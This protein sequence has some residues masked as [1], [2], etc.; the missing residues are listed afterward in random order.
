MRDELDK[1]NTMNKN[2]NDDILPL[3]QDSEEKEDKSGLLSLNEEFDNNNNSEMEDT[4]ED[5]LA[6][7]DMIS[8][9]DEA[10][11]K[12]DSVV[13][14]PVEEKEENIPEQTAQTE[15]PSLSDDIFSIDDMTSEITNNPEE[16]ASKE[17][18]PANDMG[19]IFS[20]VLSAVDGLE[21]K[22]E[23]DLDLSSSSGSNNVNPDSEDL[24]ENKKQKKKSFIKRLFGQK[25][26]DQGDTKQ[27]EKSASEEETAK[28]QEPAEI[29]TK[30][31]KK[32]A[33]PKKKAK[34]AKINKADSG[35]SDESGELTDKKNEKVN[36]NKTVKKK[37]KKEK[38]KKAK[39]IEKKS[40]TN[41]KS[42]QDEDNI[43]INKL[44]V[45]FVMTFF[46]LIGG[47][48]IIG[49][50]LYTYS[51]N[52]K[53]AETDFSRQR[54]MEAYNRIYG[55]DIRKKDSAVYDKIMT[56]MF[57]EKELNSYYNYMDIQMYPEALDSLL[58]GM[59]RYD[60]YIER[61]TKLGIQED[62]DYVR[63]QIL[64]ELKQG[65]NISEQ[66]AAALNDSDNQTQYSINV[67]NTAIEKR[68]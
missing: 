61:G 20:D 51:L 46:I 4:D 67:I 45:V 59:E 15:E 66:E 28:K 5:L 24:E 57:V 58:K 42:V 43:K 23:P 50:N 11:V 54:Y 37:K 33:E 56:V 12:K 65:F 10:N 26:E 49:T 47:F 68:E 17:E 44:A 34:K 18:K 52:I 21:D 41:E 8:A 3:V 27:S 13:P 25:E 9:Q 16:E 14:P 60:K 30:K 36:L 32:K 7:L 53:N 29:K 35:N 55:L 1:E 63:E 31:V 40:D 38:V 64:S 22:E 48:I 19:D 39:N 2:M 62:M 6:L